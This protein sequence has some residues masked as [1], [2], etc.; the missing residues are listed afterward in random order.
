MKKGLLSHSPR[1]VAAAVCAIALLCCLSL[2]KQGMAQAQNRKEAVKKEQTQKQKR[3]PYSRPTPTR[4]IRPTVPDVNRNQTDKVFLEYADSLYKTPTGFM[5]R[6]RQ[7]LKGS[8]KFRQAGMWMYCDS[9]YYYPEQNSLDA[10]GN[11]KMEQG[12]TLFVFADKLFYNGD[13]RMALLRCGPTQRQVKMENRDVVLLTDSFDYDL[14]GERGWYA[15]GGKLIDGTNTL[16]SVYGEY[17]P[18]TKRAEFFHDVVLVNNTDGYRLLS[19]TLYYNTGTHIADIVS[20]TLIEGKTDTIRTTRGFYN[21]ETD[22]AELTARSTIMHR[23][24]ADNVTTLTGDSIIYDRTTRI[25]RAFMFRD[26]LR[27]PQPMVLT[28]TAHK[29]ILIGGFGMYNDATK[30]AMATEYPLLM[31]FSRPDTLFLRADTILTYMIN[32]TLPARRPEVALD[33]IAADSIASGSIATD[34]IASGSIAA[35]SIASGSIATDLI[36]PDS[37]PAVEPRKEYHVALA[38]PNARFFNQDISGVCDTLRFVELDSM[39]YMVKKPVVW[40]GERQVM[41]NRI[42]VHLNDST[43]DWA[44]LPDWGMMIEHVDEDF[45]NQLC[46]RDMTATFEN[47]DLRNLY[48]EKNVQSIFLPMENDSTYNKMV[49]AESGFLSIDMDKKDLKHLKMWPD[50]SGTVTPTFLVKNAD[51]RL[52]YFQWLEAIR[53][54]REWYGDRIKWADDL[55]DVP[56]ELIQY[57]SLPSVFPASAVKS[58]EDF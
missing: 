34:S 28:D 58:E 41:G 38:Y 54:R 18:P 40:N 23:D 3:D 5:E 31:E 9:A 21:T 36:S 45:Y 12:D 53:P 30:E 10:F 33:S 44:H 22:Y 13:T 57:L 14:A 51:K 32:D 27:N 2:M 50:V 47:G 25:S 55:G 43:V 52:Q 39:L 11:V 35:D 19:D 49:T 46:G 17:S 26:P 29:S 24:S 8:V 7:I 16:T 15:N 48:V 4:P 1:R 42:D 20:S 56:E 6:E 37:L